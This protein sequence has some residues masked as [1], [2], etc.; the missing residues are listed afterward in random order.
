MDTQ[1][2]QDI[3][4]IE[5]E[6]WLCQL[7]GVVLVLVDGLSGQVSF[8]RMPLLIF[9]TFLVRTMHHFSFS[10]CNR[11]LYRNMF[12]LSLG[13]FVAMNAFPL[14]YDVDFLHFHRKNWMYVF[15]LFGSQ[16]GVCSLCD[17]QW[18]SG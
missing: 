6:G 16:F 18:R 9:C 11:I 8:L 4:V 15:F 12:R 14:I 17:C 13:F 10:M 1:W 5:P 3:P 2:P 7:T